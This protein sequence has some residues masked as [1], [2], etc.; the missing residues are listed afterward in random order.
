VSHALQIIEEYQLE[1][2]GGVTMDF[3]YE[4]A[5][6]FLMGAAEDDEDAYDD[7]K[8]QHK[9]YLEGYWIGKYPVTNDQFRIYVNN[10][11]GEKPEYAD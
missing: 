1:L 6:E 2:P 4:P 11:G 8:P 9:V 3:V 5:G 10:G 7:E